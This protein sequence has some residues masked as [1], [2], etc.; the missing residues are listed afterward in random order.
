M[1]R[2]YRKTLV[3]LIAA[4]MLLTMSV[5]S[6]AALLQVSSD[7][8][9]N[10]FTAVKVDTKI[11]ETFDASGKSSITVE[12]KQADENMDVYVR[13]AVVGNWV[14]GGKIVEKWTLTDDYI[15][16]TN[17]WVIG[18][19]G[20]YYY[21]QVLEVGTS[22]ENLLAKTITQ[23]TRADDAKLEVTVVHQ[24]IQYLPTSAVTQAWGV[25]V[26]QDGTIRK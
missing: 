18:N 14:K 7:P 3:L 20:F 12:N 9:E 13:V 4:A 25:T 5:G 8:V 22:T 6:T 19:D 23:A 21:K 10:V 15:N 26:A 24:A 11:N 16:T 2:S 17:N 1:K